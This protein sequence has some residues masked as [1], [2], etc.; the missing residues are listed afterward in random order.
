MGADANGWPDEAHE[1]VTQAIAGRLPRDAAEYASRIA[2]DVVLALAPFLAAQ[3]AAA[4]AAG[5][6][7]MRAVCASVAGTTRAHNTSAADMRE[8]IVRKIHR[9]PLP[10]PDTLARVKAEMQT[11]W[12]DT[13]AEAKARVWERAEA[14]VKRMCGCGAGADDDCCEPVQAIRAAAKER[15]V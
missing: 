12:R 9:A 13:I 2:S 8:T 14:A 7:A 6:E 3:G 1:A 11:L 10:A 4:Q 5:A 15:Q